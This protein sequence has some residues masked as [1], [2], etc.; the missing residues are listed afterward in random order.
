MTKRCPACGES[1]DI[2]EFQKNRTRRDGLQSH[3]KRC[4]KTRYNNYTPERRRADHIKQEYGISWNEYLEILIDQEYK[5]RICGRPIT[6]LN[7]GVKIKTV[8]HVDHDHK[9][10]EIRGV[11]CHWCNAGLGYFD[12]DIEVLEEALVYLQYFKHKKGK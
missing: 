12:D 5:C 1:K 4:F 2:T 7:G 6:V 11:L 3:C 8:G 9:T 10:G